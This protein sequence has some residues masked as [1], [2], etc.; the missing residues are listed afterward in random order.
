MPTTPSADFTDN[1]EG[2]VTHKTTGLVWKRCP[3]GQSFVASACTGSAKAVTW[4]DAKSLA[5]DGWRLPSIAELLSIVEREAQDPAINSAI[6]PGLANS[7]AVNFWSSTPYAA[8]AAQAWHVRLVGEFH[9][10]RIYGSGSGVPAPVGDSNYVRLVRGGNAQGTPSIS[11]P[12]SDFTDNGN[13]TVTHKAT[14]LTW[15]R[16]T[17]GSDWGNGKCVK[18]ASSSID[19]FSQDDALNFKG[20][21][22]AGYSDW[23]LPT[24]N[25]LL[26]LVDYG[27]IDLALNSTIFPISAA[28]LWSATS[29][30]TNGG[31]LLYADGSSDVDFPPWKKNAL[32][33]RGGSSDSPP[34]APRFIDPPSSATVNFYVAFNIEAG[35][36]PEGG[37]VAL[38][39]SATQSTPGDLPDAN[40]VVGGTVVRYAFKFSTTGQQTVTCKTIDGVGNASSIATQTITIK[41][42]NPAFDCFILW[43]EKTYPELFPSPWF[44]DRRLTQGSYYY[45]YYPA[46]NAYLGFSLLDSNVYY[47][48]NQTNN[49]IIVV[50]TQAEWF[51]KAGCQ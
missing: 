44:A 34:Y 9:S 1:G 8:D 43:A 40:P 3:E 16:C 31:W 24:E 39:C 6:F 41:A 18:S 11:K 12:D 29:Y 33:V 21:W 46:T 51:H 38:A 14:G 22:Y 42:V 49:T 27:K 50:G 36:D 19:T 23:R 17:E 15:K 28:A 35:G 2:T 47:M 13:G 45:Q 4:Q 10:Y 30:P 25:E 7:G 48:G 32:L 26:T 5:A 37:K 20:S